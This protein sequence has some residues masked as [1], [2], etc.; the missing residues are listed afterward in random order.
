MFPF[1]N[2]DT[3]N[4]VKA[5]ITSNTVADAEVILYIIDST[6]FNTGNFGNAI[7]TSDL[8][9]VTP[10]DVANGYIEIQ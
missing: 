1:L 4:S 7:F 10:N 6:E 5:I 3:I 8:Y 9:L 2:S